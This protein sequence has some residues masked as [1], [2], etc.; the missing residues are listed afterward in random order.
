VARDVDGAGGRR[1]LSAYLVTALD[2]Y[3]DYKLREGQLDR[4][5]PSGA[6]V[7]PLVR[8]RQAACGQVIGDAPLEAVLTE[9]PR[10]G[11]AHLFLGQLAFARGTLRTAEKHFLQAVAAIPDLTAGDV[12]LGRCTS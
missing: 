5:R 6:N 7:P 11:E 12:G 9:V 1:L 8:Y 4:W 2:C 3:Y 10:F